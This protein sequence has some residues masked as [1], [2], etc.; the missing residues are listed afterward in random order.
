MLCS[1]WRPTSLL[2][3][4]SKLFESFL[5]RLKIFIETNLSLSD[6]QLAFRLMRLTE[7]LLALTIQPWVNAM[8]AGLEVDLIF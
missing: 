5:E 7:F 3:P 2:Y 4:V 6:D 1:R 8:A